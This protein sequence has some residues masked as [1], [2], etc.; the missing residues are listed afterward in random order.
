[1]EIKQWVSSASYTYNNNLQLKAIQRA[2]SQIVAIY[3]MHSITKPFD[4][5]TCQGDMIKYNV[6]SQTLEVL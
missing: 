3:D 2:V 6:S 1:M 5:N 4:T